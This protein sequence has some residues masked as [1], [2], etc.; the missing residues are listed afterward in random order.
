MVGLSSTYEAHLFGRYLLT[1]AKQG[2]GLGG[3]E[4]VEIIHFL[5]TPGRY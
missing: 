5:N 3:G 4:G 2:T 1:E